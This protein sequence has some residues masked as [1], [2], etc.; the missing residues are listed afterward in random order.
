MSTSYSA[1][2]L[3]GIRLDEEDL[4]IKT[5][6]PLWGKH[7]FDPDTGEKVTQFIEKSVCADELVDGLSTSYVDDCAVYAH[8][9]DEQVFLGHT[10]AEV[11]CFRSD[12]QSVVPGDCDPSTK[13]AVINALTQRLHEQLPQLE[14]SREDFKTYLVLYFG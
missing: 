6:H 13:E 7:K 12:S 14:F 1:I 4:K 9:G 10:I 3:F 2:L 8:D 11:E 5:P